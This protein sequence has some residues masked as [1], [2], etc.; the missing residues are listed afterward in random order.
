MQTLARYKC[1]YLQGE[2][3]V[4][5]IDMVYIGMCLSMTRLLAEDG[6]HP[7]RSLEIESAAHGS[8][9]ISASYCFT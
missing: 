5:S 9:M 2:I 1:S 4:Q 6:S 8:T 3:V 7:L